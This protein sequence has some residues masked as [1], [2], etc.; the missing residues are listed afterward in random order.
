M[1]IA[2]PPPCLSHCLIE[3][4]D[5]SESITVFHRA[6]DYMLAIHTETEQKKAN[7]IVR[8]V[9]KK[10]RAGTLRFVALKA[11]PDDSTRPQSDQLIQASLF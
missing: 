7:K 2:V 3:L 4:A 9:I 6:K 11:I 1:F 10:H 5:V 8:D